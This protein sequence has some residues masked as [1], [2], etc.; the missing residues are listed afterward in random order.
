MRGLILITGVE[1]KEG[2]WGL[3]SAHIDDPEIIDAIKESIAYHEQTP[4]TDNSVLVFSSAH[5]RDGSRIAS[6]CVSVADTSDIPLDDAELVSGAFNHSQNPI[7]AVELFDEFGQWVKDGVDI[8]QAIADKWPD[9][10]PEWV[11][12]YYSWWMSTHGK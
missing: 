5:S 3:M 7:E 12:G 8:E 1:D 4:K 6:M 11:A 2:G 9:G 10:V